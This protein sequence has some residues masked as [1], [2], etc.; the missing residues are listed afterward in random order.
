MAAV[1]R[2]S[3]PPRIGRT[4]K[5]RVRCTWASRR[6][7]TSGPAS[8]ATPWR[9]C[10]S[11]KPARYDATGGELN[12]SIPTTYRA[13]V[14][15][16]VVLRRVVDDADAAVVTAF[17]ELHWPHWV[18]E[19]RRGIEQGGCH[20]AFDQRGPRGSRVRVSLGEPRPAGSVRWAPTRQS[21]RPRRRSRAARARCASI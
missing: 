14:P 1:V 10:V 16:G 20:A 11:P 15:D 12:M 4:R 2:S 18:A 5:A 9:C 8:R 7:S 6:R 13:P 19:L 3:L 21:S 17:T